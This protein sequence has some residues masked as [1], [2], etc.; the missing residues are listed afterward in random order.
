MFV[1]G[2][3][4]TFANLLGFNT[5][6]VKTVATAGLVHDIGKVNTPE[7]ILSKPQRLDPRE[8]EVMMRHPS[9][10]AAILEGSV[11]SGGVNSLAPWA[12][13]YF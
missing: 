8:W 1:T 7:A 3:L 2:T 9:D 6:D 5:E 12:R 11:H 4:V 13:G 10:G